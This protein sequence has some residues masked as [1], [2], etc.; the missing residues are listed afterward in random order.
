MSSRIGQSLAL[1]TLLVATTAQAGVF[2]CKVGGKITFSDTRAR[3]RR[4]RSM[5]STQVQRDRSRRCT[6]PLRAHYG[7]A[8]R[9]G[10]RPRHW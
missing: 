7:E 10:A 2:K 9:S 1:I 6:R 3:R 8:G 4:K 5:L